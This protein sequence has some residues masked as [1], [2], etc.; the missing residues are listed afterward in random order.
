MYR[1]TSV[2]P[3]S[4]YKS[5]GLTPHV[6]LVLGRFYLHDSLD[7]PSGLLLY[8]WCLLHLILPMEVRAS[9]YSDLHL[10]PPHLLLLPASAAALL[11]HCLPSPPPDSHAM[12]AALFG[13]RGALPYFPRDRCTGVPWLLCVAV[14]GMAA[15]SP[16]YLPV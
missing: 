3:W 7:L 13:E 2:T 6:S 9:R 4:V 8:A 10:T 16:L 5:Q 11:P 12:C 15:G 14:L 1:S